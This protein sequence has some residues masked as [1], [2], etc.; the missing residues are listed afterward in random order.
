M[1]RVARVSI[2]LPFLVFAGCSGGDPTPPATSSVSEAIIGGVTDSG[3]GAH[4]SVVM[5][6]NP[7]GACTGS[8]IAPKLVLTARHCVSQNITQGIGCDIY[9]TSSNG[10]HVGADYSPSSFSIYTGVNPNWGSPVAKGAQLFH[11][12]GKNLCNDDIALIVLDKAVTGLTPL[13]IRLDFG[14]QIGELLT[15][16]GYGA[17]NDNQ[18]GA[19]TRRRRANVPVRSVGQDWNELNGVG[20]FSTGQAVCSGDSGGP[21]FSP[22]GGVIGIASRVSNCSDPNASAKYVRLDYHKDLILQAFA[23]AGASPVLEPGTAPT[24]PTPKDVGE[25]CKTGADCKSFLCG[26][27]SI[28]SQFCSGTSCP[29]GTYCAD[30][31]IVISGQSVQENTCV[32]LPASTACEQC[33]AGDCVNVTTTCLNNPDCKAILDCADAC[34]DSACLQGCQAGHAGGADDYDSLSYCA[35]QTCPTECANL[36]TGTGGSGGAGGAPSGG[37]G[38]VGAAGGGG[39]GNVGGF[40]GAAGA[41]Q[42]TNSSSGSSGG[43]STSGGRAPN[44]PW[45]ALLGLAA[46]LVRRRRRVS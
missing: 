45:W 4:P 1:I 37:S 15:A 33:R 12:S 3:T 43:C 11:V 6:T 5:L 36:C 46:V 20:E 44:A 24:P 41:P 40:A 19:G 42:T 16:V 25:S 30:S 2:A 9:G 13:P 18:V 31:T 17:V 26:Q 22:A 14:P 21:V 27:G 32:K 39:V 34:S 28:C 8:L 35:C 29:T 23:A 38:G 7:G 10:D